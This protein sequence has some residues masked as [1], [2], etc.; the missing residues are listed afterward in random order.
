MIVDGRSPDLAIGSFT[1][2]GPWVVDPDAMP[3]RRDVEQLRRQAREQFPRW[4]ETGHLPPLGRL[5]QVVG[6]VGAALAV[7]AAGARR[8]GSPHSR[9]DLSRRLRIAFGHLGPTYIKL[10]QIVS[11][12]EGL[13]PEELVAEFKL[14]RDRVPPAP[15]EAVRPVVEL[16]LGRSLD[17]VF[18]SFARRPLAAA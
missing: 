10:G 15:F 17:D 8:R 13:F 1:D 3:W 4:M 7:W 18:S 14:P 16:D 9:P 12:G 11:G 6:R 2:H 5:A